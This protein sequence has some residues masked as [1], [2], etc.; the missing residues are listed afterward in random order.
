M[1]FFISSRKGQKEI[2]GGICR[3]NK[4]KL[5][6]VG[7]T[8]DHFHALISVPSTLSIAKVLQFIK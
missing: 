7:G 5:L 1:C 4:I 8:N 6:A 3:D 2:C